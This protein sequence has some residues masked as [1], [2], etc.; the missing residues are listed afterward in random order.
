MSVRRIALAAALSAALALPM[1]A[2]A[3]TTPQQVVKVTVKG[4]PGGSLQING[5]I[6]FSPAKVAPG[7]VIFRIRNTDKDEHLFA[8][9]GAESHWIA[10]NHTATLKVKFTRRGRYVGACPDADGAIS[11]LL[12]VT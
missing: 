1:H 8:I 3:A 4:H 12:S 10:P 11:G 5:V 2:L 7:T 9:N 6:S